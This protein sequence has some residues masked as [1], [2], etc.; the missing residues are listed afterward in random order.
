MGLSVQPQQPELL[1]PGDGLINLIETSTECC[2]PTVSL[3]FES[4]QHAAPVQKVS[5]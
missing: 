4:R 3:F 5:L 1:E 2:V